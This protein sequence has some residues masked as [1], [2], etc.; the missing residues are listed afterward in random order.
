L[1]ITY[2][3]AYTYFGAG[4]FKMALKCINEVLNDNEKMLRQDVYSFARIF[5]LVI[6]FELN[7]HEFLEYDMKSTA[8][9][10]NKHEKDYEVEKLFMREMRSRARLGKDADQKKAL[11]DFSNKLEKLLK[12]DRE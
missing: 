9:Y 5:N 3:K 12:V 1:L 4:N 2:N 6:H 10:L 8:R 11:V 7:N